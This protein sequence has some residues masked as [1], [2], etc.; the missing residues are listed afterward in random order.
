MGL[1]DDSAVLRAVLM[2]HESEFRAFAKTLE[3]DF[4]SVTTES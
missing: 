3:L 1:A 2:G 4:G